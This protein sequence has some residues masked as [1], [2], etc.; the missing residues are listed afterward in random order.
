VPI[1]V[2]DNRGGNWFWLHN[3]IVDV[4]GAQLGPY[5][6]WIYVAL[7]RHSNM[8]QTAWVSHRKMAEETGISDRKLRDELKRLEVL[9]LI[10]IEQR[11]D[12]RGQQTNVYT[13]LDPLVGPATPLA[14]DATPLAQRTS[15]PGTADQPPWHDTPTMKKTQLTRLTEQ[16]E[17]A[18][19]NLFSPAR[20]STNGSAVAGDSTLFQVWQAVLADLREQIVP[21]NYQRWLSRTSLLSHEAGAA[22]VGVPDQVSAD[23]LARRFDPL[24]RRALAD[25][26]GEAVTVQYRVVE[27]K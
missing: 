4:H 7:C 14:R 2:R 26:C 5:A 12:D 10:T 3:A 9:G 15:P 21:T 24:V 8:E 13:L 17:A 23:Q 1:Q 20:V 22:V 19:T 11:L 6:G 16:E 25:A 18:P 27:G